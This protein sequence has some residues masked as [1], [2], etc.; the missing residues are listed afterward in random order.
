[1]Q[2]CRKP[3]QK[4]GS[5]PIVGKQTIRIP[6]KSAENLGKRRVPYPLKEFPRELVTRKHKNEGIVRDIPTKF[7]SQVRLESETCIGTQASHA[8]LLQ[9]PACKSEMD[10]KK[11]LSLI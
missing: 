2:I 9:F 10:D 3:W 1:L 6:S 4:E 11:K 5:I 8:S 7:Q